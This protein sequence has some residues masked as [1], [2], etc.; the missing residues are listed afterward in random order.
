[1]DSNS[2]DVDT[3]NTQEASTTTPTA[4]TPAVAVIAATTGMPFTPPH[5]NTNTP[6]RHTDA[7]GDDYEDEQ[8]GME[9]VRPRRLNDSAVPESPSMR[10]EHGETVESSDAESDSERYQASGPRTSGSRS[11]GFRRS[12]SRT[13]I[14]S[15]SR[16]GG[17]GSDSEEVH[18]IDHTDFFS[19]F[20]PNWDSPK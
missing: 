20:G 16:H 6:Q 11:S 17:Y 7:A 5:S 18:K 19:S 13:V 15:S 8:S 3:P 10:A 14:S 1:M 2:M 12:G 9:P 4:T